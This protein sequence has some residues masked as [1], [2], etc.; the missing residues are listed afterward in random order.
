MKGLS[1]RINNIILLIGRRGSGKTFYTKQQIEAILK[2]GVHSRIILFDTFDHESYREYP[3]VDIKYVTALTA[4]VCRVLTSEFKFESH[5]AFIKNY[6]RNALLIFEDAGKYIIGSVGEQFRN[7][8]LDTK[9]KNIDVLIQYHGVGDVPPTLYRYAD[10]IVL[11][12]INDNL[13]AYRSK[14]PSFPS[15]EKHYKHVLAHPSPYYNEVF[16]IN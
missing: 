13:Q 8:L 2:S 7:V 12:K 9:Q 6:V 10:Y 5:L 14:I 3:I 16:K 4:G 1:I 11:F 15:F